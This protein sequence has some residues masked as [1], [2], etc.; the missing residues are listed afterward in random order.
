M[1]LFDLLLCSE[2]QAAFLTAALIPYSE[3]Y[4][5]EEDLNGFVEIACR[6]YIDIYEQL[7]KLSQL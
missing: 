1:S 2:V 3:E 4:S 7:D 5:K 6:L